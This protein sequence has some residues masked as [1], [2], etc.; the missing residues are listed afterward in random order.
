MHAAQ[1]LDGLDVVAS[2][3]EDGEGNK[4][5]MDYFLDDSWP[6]IPHYIIVHSLKRSSLTF[7]SVRP[8]K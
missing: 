2:H 8:L 4:V 1:L 6:F 5:Q 7:H 3:V